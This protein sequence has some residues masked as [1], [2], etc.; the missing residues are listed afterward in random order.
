MF[1]FG[2]RLVDGLTVC[3]EVLAGG[4]AEVIK[5][6]RTWAA[7]AGLTHLPE[8][9]FCGH[10]EDPLSGDARLNPKPLGFVVARDGRVAFED[11]H[12]ELCRIDAEPLWRSQQ[13]PGVGDGF[14]LEVV[15]EAEIAEH[16]EEG[17][18]AAGEADVFEIVMLSAGADAFLRGGSAGVV[19][20]LGT[21]EDILELVHAGV[22]EEQRWIIGRNERRGVHRAMHFGLEKAQKI[23]ANLVAGLR[24]HR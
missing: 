5:E 2:E 23:F 22:G 11:G 20:A 17:V 15:A 21:E 10:L 4:E 8:V 19:A 24:L 3:V 12:V 9:V 6:F 18:M 16:L 13:L 14:A 1:V 7:G